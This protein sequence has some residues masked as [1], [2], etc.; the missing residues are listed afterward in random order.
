MPFLK[1]YFKVWKTCAAYCIYGDSRL[2][3]EREHSAMYNGK[4]RY[5][6]CRYNT[7]KQQLTLGIIIIDYVKSKDNITD[8]LTKS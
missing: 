4:S 3:I 8:L 1:G 7:I 5:I 6:S 2:A